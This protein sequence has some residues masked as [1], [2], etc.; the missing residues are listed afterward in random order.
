MGDISTPAIVF[1]CCKKILNESPEQTDS[2]LQCVVCE[3][4][5][6][7][8]CLS[9]DRWEVPTNHVIVGQNQETRH[10]FAMQEASFAVTSRAI[11]GLQVGPLFCKKEVSEKLTQ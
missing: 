2:E 7:F 4:R 9:I 6:Y 1:H 8:H 3:K 5:F 10:F 11:Q